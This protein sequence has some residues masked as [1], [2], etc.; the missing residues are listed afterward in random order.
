MPCTKGVLTP[1]VLHLSF[2]CLVEVDH[3]HR[4]EDREPFQSSIWEVQH[5][6]TGES[7]SDLMD[8]LLHDGSAAV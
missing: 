7:S 6:G 5:L 3:K 4:I 1:L 8:V 2:C